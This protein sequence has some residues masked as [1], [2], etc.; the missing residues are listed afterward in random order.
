MTVYYTPTQIVQFYPM[1][2]LEAQRKA[3]KAPTSGPK[4]EGE[5]TWVDIF[6]KAGLNPQGPKDIGDGIQYEML[7]PRDLFHSTPGHT[8]ALFVTFWYD[9]KLRHM[10]CRHD[11]CDGWTTARFVSFSRALGFT[12]PGEEM[13]E[14]E[15]QSTGTP[16]APEI[17]W[18]D[19]IEEGV[20]GS[21][22]SLKGVSDTNLTRF[23]ISADELGRL[24]IPP[25]EYAVEPWLPMSGLTMC[26]GYRGTIKTWLA[27]YIAGCVAKGIPCFSYQVPMPRKVWIIDGE[28]PLVVLKER[29]NL[30]WGTKPKGLWF[31]GA[32]RLNQDGIRL[33]LNS[34]DGQE[35]FFRL[36]DEAKGTDQ[37]PDLIIG[38]N[39][40]TLL[41]G[42]KANDNDEVD[43]IMDFDL[44]LR[45]RG[46]AVFWVEH[47]GK[48]AT[49]GSRG[50]S[51]AEDPFDYIMALKKEAAGVLM[52]FTKTRGVDPNPDKV[53]IRLESYFQ[54]DALGALNPRIRLVAAG[55]EAEA[56]P[57]YVRQLI[58][59][60][61]KAP[62]TQR[63]YGVAL[64]TTSQAAG[65]TIK[66]LRERGFVKTTAYE[67][68]PK[69]VRII[70][71]YAD[72]E[73]AS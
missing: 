19:V 26:H 2:T 52:S 40:S 54:Q 15:D 28:M 66:S 18:P 35:W 27:M 3:A 30:L 34:P 61:R 37:Y 5:P 29:C 63:E 9:G 38:D 39:R 36:L 4:A 13:E 8:T 33:N 59:L 58:I 20:Q 50:A 47:E 1:D 42:R 41:L 16:E 51:R 25:R 24:D 43:N 32:E 56:L 48:D 69:A 12:I 64:G 22:V 70:S 14:E 49:K 73:D 46:H 10:E 23:L 21:T 6:R 53:L 57:M 11:H 31:L 65:R 72:W 71:D 45:F 62:K 55:A 67:L 68:T 44:K 17:V 7:C 60:Y